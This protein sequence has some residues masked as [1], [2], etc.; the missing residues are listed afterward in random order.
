MKIIVTDNYAR[1]TIADRL[2]S[3]HVHPWIAK[4]M[5]EEWQTRLCEES[6]RTG[7]EHDEWPVVVEDDYRLWRGMKDLV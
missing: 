5:V 1:E 7:Y 2:V 6:L 4:W 3:E